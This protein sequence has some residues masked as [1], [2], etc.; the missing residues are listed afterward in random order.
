MRG[1]IALVAALLC[2][3]LEAVE[4]DR[5]S[6][7][8]LAVSAVANER[9]QIWPK[10][11]MPYFQPQQVAQKRGLDGRMVFDPAEPK[12][13]FIEWYVPAASNRTQTCVLVLSGGGFNTCCDV[14]RLQPAIDRFVRAGLTVANLTYRT[15]RP[16]GLPIHQSA[17]ADA[18]RAVRVIRAEAPKRG[19]SPDRIG[20]T[21]ISAGAKAVLLLALSARTPAYE[22][23]DALDDLPCRLAFAIPQAPAYVLTDGA[24]GENVRGGEGADIV[25]ELKFDADTAPLCCLQGGVDAYSPIGSVRLYQRLTEMGVPSELHLFADRWHGFHGDANRTANG[26]AWDHWCDL[27]LDFVAQFEP[28]LVREA[29]SPC[30]RPYGELR[31]ALE[32]RGLPSV[33]VCGKGETEALRRFPEVWLDR[34]RQKVQSDLH[35]YS[36][37]I[38]DGVRAQRL[39]EFVNHRGGEDA[40][41]GAA[42]N[43]EDAQCSPAYFWMWNGKLDEAKLIAQ[44]DD[45][46]AHG[47]RSVCVHPFPKRFRTDVFES[48]MEPDYLTPGYLKVFSKVAARAQMLGMDFWLYDEGGWPS[49]GACGLV[50]KSDREGRFRRRWINAKGEVSA[51]SYAGNPPVPS[52]T[53]KG[54]TGR[55]IELTHD[56]YA[57]TLPAGSFGSSVRFAFMDEPQMV[58]DFD[59]KQLGWTADFAEVFRRKKGYD[60]L[61]RLAELIDGYDSGKE[62][63]QKL[64]I[65]FLEVRADLFV[66][67]FMLPIRD[68]CSRHGM[69]SG[70]H[71]N[72]E[73]VPE[74]TVSYGHGDLLK[75]LRAMDCPGVDVIWR[76]LFPATPESPAKMKPFPR[77]AASAMHQNGGR[78]AVSESFGIFG[79]SCTPDQMRA[80]VDSQFVRGINR[81][82][83]GYYAQSNANRWMLLFEPHSGPIVPYW[84]FEPQ[85]FRYITETAAT[86]TEGRPGAE[87]AVLYDVRGLFAGGKDNAEATR[88]HYA[89]AKA[90][91]E[92]NRDYDFVNDESLASAAVEKDGVLK[93][94]AM[95]YR[96]LVLPT[97][98]WLSDGARAKAEAFAKA[99]GLVTNVA[100]VARTPVTLPMTGDG[101]S[102]LR[103]LKRVDGARQIYFVVNEGQAPVTARIGFGKTTRDWTFARND[104]AIFTVRGESVELPRKITAGSVSRELKDGWTARRIAAHEA[105]S[106]DLVVRPV[107]EKPVSVA[108]GDWREVFDRT[109]SGKVVYRIEFESGEAREAVLDLGRVCWCAGV[110]LN[111]KD[112][113]SRFFGPFRWTVSLAKGRNVLEVT[114]ANLLSTHL[115]DPE[116]RARIK[117]AH[118]P[119]PLYEKYHG[120]ADRQN[121]ESGLFGPVVLRCCH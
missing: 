74:R 102:A 91:D 96:A 5:P 97:S 54:A 35:V 113:G 13:P 6:F 84:D 83:F 110:R 72:G 79:D 94:G 115:G 106:D 63:V 70:G 82:V 36:V 22:R 27:M 120:E 39:L 71:L 92:L 117:S 43:F 10:G 23:V 46:H 29:R 9:M 37:E 26:T 78:F 90:L 66:E 51:E 21:G 15:P 109:F 1:R 65:D 42:A 99:G 68:W 19:Y 41:V 16:Q 105:A 98:K 12:G 88:N 32:K 101:V 40:V 119:H 80:L 34:R 11:K 47:L 77:Y 56:A 60:I 100:G 62:S 73:D 67:R 25:P 103:V 48:H 8:P 58:G 121:R 61:P 87:I 38:D 53:E 76:Q 24:T 86:L 93:V 7:G 31:D 52:V 111:G 55:F 45:M 112:V 2:G 44:L 28:K 104:S 49:G 81:F 114:V 33:L 64:R 95:R 18:Q 20:A 116:V 3:A 107:D 89:A 75:S 85:F 108:L 50:A 59:G 118:K 30:A 14:R 4:K 17:W 69:L 57:K